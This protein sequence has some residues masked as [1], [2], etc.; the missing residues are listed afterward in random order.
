MDST[1]PLMPVLQALAWTAAA[2]TATIGGIAYR[3]S[4]RQNMAQALLELEKRFADFAEVARWIDP[5]ARKFRSELGP[6]IRLS[7]VA[8]DK[9]RSPEYDSHITKLDGFLRFL[10][11]VS[12]LHRFRILSRRAVGYQ[13]NYWFRELWNNRRLRAYVRTYFPTVMEFMRRNRRTITAPGRPPWIVRRLTAARRSFLRA[14]AQRRRMHD[15]P[16]TPSPGSAR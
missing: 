8:K 5:E 7:L 10:L 12:N 14:R 2:V 1:V 4:V 6:H 11:L 3:R 15:V 16:V 9:P 13:Y